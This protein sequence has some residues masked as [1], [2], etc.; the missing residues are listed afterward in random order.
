[1]GVFPIFL[2]FGRNFTNKVN[3][4]ACVN[5][6]QTLFSGPSTEGVPE[7]PDPTRPRAREEVLRKACCLYCPEKDLAQA[8]S[9]EQQAEAEE[10]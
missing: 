4:F 2:V 8:H 1:M 9:Q 6:N 7:D 5:Q 10:A 3:I